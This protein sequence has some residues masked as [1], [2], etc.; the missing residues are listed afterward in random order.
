MRS[1]LISFATVVA[2]VTWLAQGASAAPIQTFDGPVTLS[3]TQA[4]GA[5]YVDRY[6]P[7]G[8]VG[9]VNGGGRIGVLQHSINAADS[10]NARPGAFSSAFYNTQGRKYDLASGTTSMSIDLYVP[11]AWATTNSR[12]AGFWGTATDASNAVSAF[13]IVEFTSDAMN[14]RFRGWD[15]LLGGFVDM[16]LPAGFAYD[17]WQTLNIDLIGTDFVYSIGNLSLSFDANGS[18]SI[19]NTILQGHNTTTGVTYDIL[20]D[21]LQGPSAASE[22]PEPASIALWSLMSVAGLAAWRRRKLA[23]AA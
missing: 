22:V 19:A 1:L 14:P 13:P 20:W 23:T 11:A 16:G 5:W 4:P 9:G 2:A 6:A 17:E 15:T 8:F 10:G 12:M 18:T 21:N 7:A 3:P